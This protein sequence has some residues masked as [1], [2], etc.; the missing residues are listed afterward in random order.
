MSKLLIGSLAIGLGLTS[1]SLAGEKASQTSSNETVKGAAMT[2]SGCVV[3]DKDKD[4]SVVLMDVQEISGPSSVVPNPTLTGMGLTG[5][6]LNTIYWLSSETVKLVRPHDGHRVEISGTI[7]DVSTGTTKI[8]QE[9]GKP[10]PDNDIKIEVSARGKE[11]SVETEKPII[12]GPTPVTKTEETKTL[13]VRRIKVETV[14]MLSS[15]CS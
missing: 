15:T 13:P 9:P 14:K 6:S 7:T 3:V 11:A 12:P 4:N 2:I 10:G 5:G 8:T 1:T